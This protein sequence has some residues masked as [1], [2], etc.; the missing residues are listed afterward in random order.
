VCVC[1]CVCVYVSVCVRAHTHSQAGGWEECVHHVPLLWVL[2][3]GVAEEP[4]DDGHL[5][6]LEIL[7]ARHHVELVPVHDAQKLFPHVGGT[8]QVARLC[9]SVR[10]CVRVDVCVSVCVCACVCVC[11]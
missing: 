11:C 3:G 8:P 10:G 9:W 7:A 1:V 6:T 2:L 5:N 4:R